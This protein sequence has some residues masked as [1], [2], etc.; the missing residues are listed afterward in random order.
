[1]DVAVKPELM[2]AAMDRPI[3]LP[4]WRRKGWQQVLGAGAALL[5]AIVTA[6]VLIGPAQRSFRMSA[7]AARIATVEQGVYRDFIPLRGEVVPL[8]TVYLDA[9]EGGRVDRILVQP[10]D[11]V[12]AGQPLAEF[13][14][15]SLELEVR[16]RVG[17]LIG[18]ITQLQSFETQLEQNRLSNERVLSD[19]EYDVTRLTRALER[20][21]VLLSVGA[22]TA[23]SRDELRYQ[24]DRALRQ[25]KTQQESNA[26]QEALRQQQ[27]PQVRER[28]AML[29]ETLTITHD[30]LRDLTVRAP[31]EGLVTQMDIKV[32]ESRSRGERLAEITPQTGHRLSATIDEYYLGRIRTG[33]IARVERGGQQWPL[34]VERVYPQVKDGGFHIDLTFDG[35]PPPGLL[36]GQ[37][38]QGRLSL[39]EDEPGLVLV[40]GA[41]L[42]TSGGDW[43][44]VLDTD[45]SALRRR[46]KLGRRNV[47]QVEVLEGLSAGERVIVSDYAGLDRIER[48]VLTK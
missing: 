35:A 40:S 37:T 20:R 9:L 47:E 25:Q 38:L 31:V 19:I 21:E 16:D 42:E 6:V 46:I 33:Q 44:F 11:H 28:L 23:E 4:W 48:I 36:R 7:T 34:R 43:V 22:A 5:L 12:V 45:N 14:N 13:S 8:E 1:M 15:T 39:G 3:L 17:S 24:L 41:F 29:Q 27:V 26:R 30:R 32:S 2:Q 18:S 10:G